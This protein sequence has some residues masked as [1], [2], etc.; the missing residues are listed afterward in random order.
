MREWGKVNEIIYHDTDRYTMG[1]SL[2]NDQLPEAN[3]MALHVCNDEQSIIKNRHQ[4][5]DTLNIS[6]EQLVCA[7][8]THS[9]L[10]YKVTTQDCGSGA[11]TNATAI[12]NVDA[13]YT[14]EP[15]ILL[16][17]FHAD[18][19]PIIFYHE[20]RKLVGVIHSGWQGTVKEIT[21]KMFQHLINNEQC[22]PEGFHIHIGRALSQDKFEVD[23]DVYQKFHQLGYAEPYIY[24]NDETNKYH[25]DNQ[26][27]VK[28]QCVNN[29][30]S[31]EQ[32]EIDTNCTFIDSD[33]F[34]YRQN[35]QCGRHMSFIMKKDI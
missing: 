34:S 6:I 29:G 4:L 10:F 27:V 2:K 20:Q 14:Y 12:K 23:G 13:L 21:Y 15:N 32:I 17:L 22:S 19:V 1:L 16:T 9:D 35:R 5:A 7:N 8:Q 28:Q 11:L 26:Q 24:F 18:C 25:I 31:I 3:N 33:S 30:I